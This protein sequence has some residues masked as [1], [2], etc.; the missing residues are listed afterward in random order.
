MDYRIN[1]EAIV[2]CV[3][4]QV[5]K[6]GP[7]EIPFVI[8]IT[9]LMLQKKL[10]GKAR[11]TSADK[12]DELGMLYGQID[13][14]LLGVIMNSLTM[15]IEGGCIKRK[16]GNLLVTESGHQLCEEMSN[17]KSR[18]LAEV[19]KDMDEVLFK[20]DSIDRTCLYDKMWIAV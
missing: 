12:V 18:M 5:V 10:R 13:G 6:R 20:Y 11:K 14:D 16:E 3:I 7:Y 15:L 4:A 2:G 9:N 17:G 19:L 8:G 1:N